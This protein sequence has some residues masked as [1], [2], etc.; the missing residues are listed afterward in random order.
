MESSTG[1]TL[2]QP[3]WLMSTP[4]RPYCWI[5]PHSELIALEM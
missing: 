1:A 2:G 4:S 3:S 5:M